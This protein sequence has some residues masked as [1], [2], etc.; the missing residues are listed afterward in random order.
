MLRNMG[1]GVSINPIGDMT[2]GFFELVIAKK[3]NFI[4]TAKIL[5]GNTDFNP[6]IM[7]VVSVEKAD[8]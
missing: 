7:Q 4:E 6:E 2:D 1:P 3:L 5:A 8:D